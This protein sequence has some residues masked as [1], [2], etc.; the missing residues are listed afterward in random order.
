MNV[1]AWTPRRG[2]THSYCNS[3][4]LDPDWSHS[5]PLPGSARQVRIPRHIERR[6][7]R[8]DSAEIPKTISQR[9]GASLR[10]VLVKCGLSPGGCWAWLTNVTSCSEPISPR[11]FEL[12]RLEFRGR[13]NAVFERA[14]YML[15]RA[16]A[17][18]I[19][20]AESCTTSLAYCGCGGGRG[21]STSPLA[22]C[23]QHGPVSSVS[24]FK[25]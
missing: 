24:R 13:R 17:I 15:T 11:L 3:Y 14:V 20:Q 7:A 12:F 18:G 5:V 8:D 21:S 4:A 1:V 2:H 22:G 6:P 19:H 9:R 25:Q 23:Y 16:N 10:R